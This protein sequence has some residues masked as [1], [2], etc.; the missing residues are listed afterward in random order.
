MTKPRTTAIVVFVKTPGLSPIKT[1]LAAA[2]GSDHALIAYMKCLKG[3]E[4]LVE[5]SLNEFP[6]TEAF[7]AV[8]E[9]QALQ[10]PLWTAPIQGTHTHKSRVRQLTWQ[11]EGELPARLSRVFNRYKS[12]FDNVILIGADTPHIPS[13]WIGNAITQLN[14][15]SDPVAVFGPA[16]D[17]GFYLFGCNFSSA[18]VTLASIE[19]SLPTTLDDLAEQLFPVASLTWLPQLSDLDEIE[20][21]VEVRREIEQHR[22]LLEPQQLL[23]AEPI[24]SQS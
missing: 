21:L 6:E 18:G 17:G 15:E 23:L 5:A 11:G 8:A 14:K 12:T 16:R 24:T 9:E 20:D 4:T 2:I 3:V 1:R 10:H 13:R 22:A 7:W 19:Y